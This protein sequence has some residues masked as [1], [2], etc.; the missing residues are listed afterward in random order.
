VLAPYPDVAELQRRRQAARPDDGAIV[1]FYT[2]GGVYETEKDRMLRSAELL[3]LKAAATA[4][5]SA[6]SWVRNAGLKPGFLLEQRASLR[7]PLLYLDVDAV[8]HRNPWTLLRDM[9]CDI[10]AYYDDADVGEDGGGVAAVDDQGASLL[11]GTL[12]L[13]DT[14]G[15]LEILRRWQD[16]CTANPDM[17]DQRALQEVLAEDARSP[18]PLFRVARLP[19]SCCWIFDKVGNGMAGSE[20]HIEH[21]QASREAA[22]DGKAYAKAPRRLIRRRDRVA[23]I[24]RILFR[25]QAAC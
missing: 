14:P 12:L 7:G 19:V 21:L 17:W 6:G 16:R 1:A 2:P 23:T 5:S 25:R 15:A 10:A 24:E 13:N 18:D 22:P 20:V 11:S 8:L 4:V 9:A 3:G